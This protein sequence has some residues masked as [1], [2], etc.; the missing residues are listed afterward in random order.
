[1]AKA[2]CKILTLLLLM[3][4]V[5]AQ[6]WNDIYKIPNWNSPTQLAA[7]T[8]LHTIPEMGKEWRIKFDFKATSYILR[9]NVNI[10]RIQSKKK[11]TL[12]DV[13]L[14]E[15]QKL[16]FCFKIRSNECITL[17]KSGSTF[18]K[19]NQWMSF[20]IT[21]LLER[22]K[23]KFMFLVSGAQQYASDTLPPEKIEDIQIYAADGSSIFAQPGFIRKLTVSIPANEETPGHTDSSWGK[24]T[25]PWSACSV[26]C[27]NGVSRELENTSS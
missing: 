11:Y 19:L 2:N 16:G 3:I 5:K 17:P 4:L 9:Q 20:E 6:S 18:V 21:Q 1:M 8:L 10:L 24:W 15:R 23:S 25:Q 14:S 26:T 13:G 22:R 7:N 12:I 27:G